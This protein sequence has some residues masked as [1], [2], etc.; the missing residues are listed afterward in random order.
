MKK[1][2]VWLFMAILLSSSAAVAVTNSAAWFDD[3][4]RRLADID[5]QQR[6]I[7]TKLDASPGLDAAQRAKFVELEESL[8][9]EK[10]IL[11]ERLELLK[12][13][14]TQGLLMYITSSDSPTK[15]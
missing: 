12:Q 5:F 1:T 14:E 3:T 10:R 9:T 15:P 2:F 13:L 7:R 8:K 11:T 6:V 4:N